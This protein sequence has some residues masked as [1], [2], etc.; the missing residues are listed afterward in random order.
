ML[1]THLNLDDKPTSEANTSA[2][3][4][5]GMEVDPEVI[6]LAAGSGKDDLAKTSE[7]SDGESPVPD[8]HGELLIYQMPNIPNCMT[9][10]H[11]QWNMA[12]IPEATVQ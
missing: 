10:S 7:C 8:P 2:P 9:V 5:T 11:S 1:A 12:V 3:E 4:L 6:T